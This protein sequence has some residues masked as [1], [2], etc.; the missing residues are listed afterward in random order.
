MPRGV[1]PKAVVHCQHISD[2][3]KNFAKTKEG[4]ECYRR[5]GAKHKKW[6]KTKEG[7]KFFRRLGIFRGKRGAETNRKNETGA[8]FDK[9]IKSKGGKNNA[10]KHGGW[11]GCNKIFKE[12]H[13]IKY[14]EQRIKGGKVTASKY[15]D[16]AVQRGLAAITSRR[17]KYPYRFMDVPFDSEGEKE[18]AKELNA[19]A[20]FVP[21]EGV[22]CHIRIGNIE[23]DFRPFEKLFLEYHP[24]D[25]NGLSEKEYYA[26]RR[27]ILDDNGYKDCVLVV[28]KSVKELAEVLK[29]FVK[30]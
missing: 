15:P 18:V 10:L 30:K 16:L 26:A 29:R 11:F 12:K 28:I 19:Q 24:W 9:K 13:P 22:N 7:K 6:A 23:I 27:K 4:K 20:H 14:R 17:E 2:S 3:K 1:F 25:M 21:A 5:S 8:F